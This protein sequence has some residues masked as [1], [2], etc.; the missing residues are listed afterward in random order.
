MPPLLQ[1]IAG[2]DTESSGK[3]ALPNRPSTHVTLQDVRE[4]Q[5]SWSLRYQVKC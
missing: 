5:V 2:N 3:F 4:A 1:F